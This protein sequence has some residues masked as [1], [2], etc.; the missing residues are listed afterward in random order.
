M[1]IPFNQST[2]GP[3]EAAAAAACVATGGISGGGPC[4]DRA[5]SLL[6]SRLGGLRVLATT[7][8]THALELAL[9]AKGIAAGDEV[10]VPAYGFPST[11]AC[12]LRQGA[13]V[14][15][16][17]CLPDSP[18]IDPADVARKI[19]PRTRAVIPIH[20]G[21][22]PCDMPAL[23]TAAGP[24]IPII[25]DAAHALDAKLDGKPCGA[26]GDAGCLS[27]HSTKNVACGE[28]GAF[29]AEDGEAV[30]AAEEIRSMG[31]DRSRWLRGESDAYT[32]RRMGSSFIPSEV[33]MAILAV[34]LERADWI[35]AERVRRFDLYM[36]LLAGLDREGLLRLPR[37]PAG[38]E[39]NGHIFHVVL[40]DAATAARAI[41]G[42]HASGI[43]A[44]R[45]FDALDETPFG[46]TL[47]DHPSRACPNAR[48]LSKRLVRLPLYPGL[49]EA[50]QEEVVS[51]LRSHLLAPAR[52]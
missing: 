17:D 34:Q 12:A 19:S 1:R 28:G 44:T 16:A 7:S 9:M 15:F 26:L 27:F 49:A 20:Y 38:A 18:Q 30:R 43:E 29:I 24:D 31:T 41:A 39:P 6:R 45:H 11:A 47:L 35:L 2:I 46:S 50:D 3:L 22:V 51:A 8:G 52:P 42:M 13:R 25:E 48:S 10:V 32:W 36:D 5:E 23:R 37:I 33:L 14:V 40:P 4:L 21:G